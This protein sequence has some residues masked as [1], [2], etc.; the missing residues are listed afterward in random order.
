LRLPDCGYWYRHVDGLTVRGVQT[1]LVQ[2][3]V[4]PLT[5]LDDAREANLT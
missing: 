4:R 2:S 5:G 3:D 1:A